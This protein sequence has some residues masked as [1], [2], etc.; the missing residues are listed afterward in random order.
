MWIPPE[1]L[2]SCVNFM[3]SV[4][5]IHGFKN[6]HSDYWSQQ[7]QTSLIVFE[8]V[9]FYLTKTKYGVRKCSHN[10]NWTRPTMVISERQCCQVSGSVKSAD[11]WQLKQCNHREQLGSIYIL[12]IVGHSSRNWASFI[13]LRPDRI[14]AEVALRQNSVITDP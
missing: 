4:S 6:C 12:A 3:L 13:S 10:F 11:C 8:L 1:K 5:F 9:D 7:L 2:S 14:G